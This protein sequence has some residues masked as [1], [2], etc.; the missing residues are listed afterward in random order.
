MRQTQHPLGNTSLH[1]AFEVT[2][3]ELKGTLRCDSS[4]GGKYITTD[5]HTSNV[6]SYYL[7]FQLFVQIL[8]LY[9]PRSTRHYNAPEKDFWVNSS[10]IT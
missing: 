9:L 6:V 7:E 8:C 10:T 3:S 5:R 2:F 4:E 1:K